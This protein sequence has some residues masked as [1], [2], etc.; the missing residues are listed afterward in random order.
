MAYQFQSLGF[1]GAE[2]DDS[3]VAD[4]NARGA[5]VGYTLASSYMSGARPFVWSP[6]TG[7]MHDLFPND[8]TIEHGYA[9]AINEVGR[10]AGYLVE[11]GNSGAAVRAFVRQ[12][13]YSARLSAPSPYLAAV[14]YGIN[15]SGIPVGALYSSLELAAPDAASRGQPPVRI[16]AGPPLQRI[17]PHAAYDINDA[18]FIAAETRIDG[19]NT[20]VLIAPA[21]ASWVALRGAT[22]AAT[23]VR[24]V[25]NQGMCAGWWARGQKN[26][27]SVWKDTGARHDIGA[28]PEDK[29]SWA[30]DLNASGL[31][32]GMSSRGNARRAF[33]WSLQNGIVDLNAVTS[34]LPQGWVLASAKAINDKGTIAVDALRPDAGMQACRLVPA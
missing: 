27:A 15:A 29:W 26:V 7:Q 17:R 6:Q 19:I 32:V 20:A 21:L 11:D 24:R 13:F 31:A 34:G 23:F 22:G 3:S 28:L 18:G 14:Y 10:A 25:N 9:T 33:V 12:G 5:V 1:L 4:I 16:V 2:G 8:S 30:F